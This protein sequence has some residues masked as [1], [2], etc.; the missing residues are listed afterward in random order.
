M[1]DRGETNVSIGH[2]LFSKE[3]NIVGTGARNY[4][5]LGFSDVVLAE[6]PHEMIQSAEIMPSQFYGGRRG[7]ADYEG[8]EKLWLAVLEDTLRTLARGADWGSDRA[9]KYWRE[10]DTWLRD[11]S[12]DDREGTFVFVCQVLKLNPV[13]FHEQLAKGNVRDI[14][15]RIAARYGGGVN[16]SA[17]KVR[18]KTVRLRTLP[19]S[20]PQQ[21]MP[22]GKRTKEMTLPE[23]H[24]CAL[25]GEP[26]RLRKCS[27]CRSK[28]DPRD[29]P[30]ER[31][32]P[33][34]EVMTEIYDYHEDK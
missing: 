29:E 12:G 19:S 23:E 16:P 32:L 3:L 17:N 21:I 18:R 5:S 33:G 26:T 11:L 20:G 30:T 9:K 24:P 2:G 4:H 7:M 10:A 34:P 25:C 13:Y 27:A 15:K 31:G 1:R 22:Q 28:Q 8:E 6:I 14:H